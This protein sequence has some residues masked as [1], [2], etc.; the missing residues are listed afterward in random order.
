MPFIIGRK[1]D[2]K[3]WDYIIGDIHGREWPSSIAVDRYQYLRKFAWKYG[4]N[5]K[6]SFRDPNTGA[7]AKWLPFPHLLWDNGITATVDVHRSVLENEI[8]IE[9]DYPTYE[10]NYNASRIIGTIIENKGFIPHYYYSGNKSIHIHVFLDW[11]FIIKKIK[12]TEQIIIDSK[13]LKNDEAF[14]RDFINWLREKMISCWDTQARQFDRDLIRANHLIRAELS[15]N[16]KGFK[17]FLGYSIKD[18][19]F[20]P[21]VCNES[22]LIYP[23]LGEIKVSLPTS[24]DELIEEFVNHLEA[25][26]RK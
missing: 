13:Y 17:T 12:Y 18:V 25:I 16:K 1:Q 21:I 5:F 14:K 19:S 9:S 11:E 22:N 7:W 8:V 2:H 10:E 24:S 6:L 15:K 3:L 23:K 4:D 20:I 26:S